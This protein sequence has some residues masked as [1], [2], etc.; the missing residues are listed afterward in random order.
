MIEGL[1]VIDKPPG[2]TSHDVVDKVREI[3]GERKVGH[4]GT[5]DPDATG[6]L[7]V[8]IGRATRFLSYAQEGPKRYT[9]VARF[10]TTTT[11]QD[12]GGDVVQKRGSSFAREQL[13]EVA[14]GFVGDIEQVPPMVSAVK[15][16]GQRLHRLARRGK[17]IE[18]KPRPQRVYELEVVDFSPGEEPEATLDVRCSAGTYVRTLIHDIGEAL[19]S[20]AHMRSLVRTES[21]GFT[22]SDA[23]ALDRIG[24][25]HVRPLV[26]T[27]RALFR[28]EVDA[29]AVKLVSN[30]RPLNLFG[31][32]LPGV[33]EGDHVAITSDER[34]LGVYRLDGERLMPDRV[35]GTR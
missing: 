2:M 10:G 31:A 16:A 4:A 3:L 24:E 8:G 21:G 12:A 23:V 1:L 22:L 33:E 13:E 9:A 11:T 19:G 17:E 32:R 20:G 30:G 14:T 7:L 6:V 27:V 25:E 35:M 15:V 5:L 26:D 28:F 29:D 18:R 34:L